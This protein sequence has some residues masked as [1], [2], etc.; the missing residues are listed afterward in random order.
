MD[1][2][3]DDEIE[4][5]LSAYAAGTLTPDE[6]KRLFE[7]SL[8][9]QQLFDA[10]AD[11]E[12]MRA[13]LAMPLVKESLIELLDETDRE[14]REIHL[15]G[16]A[17][18]PAPLATE[19]SQ[20]MR[21]LWAAVA[22]CLLFG[23]ISVTLWPTKSVIQVSEVKQQPVLVAENK[24]APEP[25]RT[26]VP[27]AQSPLP[28]LPAEKARRT[29]ST[30]PIQ[31]KLADQPPAAPTVAPELKAK[32]EMQ[33]AK[34]SFESRADAA[35][36]APKLSIAVS[37]DTT[38][39]ST[40]AEPQANRFN[41]VAGKLGAAASAIAKAAPIAAIGRNNLAVIAAANNRVY[42]FLIDGATIRVLTPTDEAKRLYPLGDHSTQA[43]VWLLVTPTEDP[44]LERALTGVL[45]L[46]A[47]NWIKLKMN[48]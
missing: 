37:A 3:F 18:S 11:E 16:A 6:K 20:N 30:Q 2:R 23:I 21:L 9:N 15:L 33:D 19:R 35:P 39:L 22:A 5:L 25:L 29:S 10:L 12:A 32:K 48:P 45:P 46:P 28:Q 34:A 1:H 40:T 26:P 31:E 24:P 36:P 14:H 17:Q 47:R 27:A 43:E 4:A 8:G 41:A 44:V 42:A 7:K 38:A 13:A